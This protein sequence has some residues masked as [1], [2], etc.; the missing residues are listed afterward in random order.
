MV[1]HSRDL[2]LAAQRILTHVKGY[3]AFNSSDAMVM[4][5]KAAL[6]LTVAHALGSAPHSKAT[7]F[8]DKFNAS[9]PDP[10]ID[11]IVDYFTSLQSL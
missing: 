1:S 3:G 4:L 9:F 8:V 7:Y 6:A 10:H 11:D 2:S 5:N